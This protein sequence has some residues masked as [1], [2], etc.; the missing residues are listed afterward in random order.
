MT[1]EDAA[2]RR[3]GTLIANKYRLRRVIGRGGMGAVYDSVH[4]FTGK[5]CAVKVLDPAASHVAGYA[6]RFLREARAAAQIG[7]PG[8][9]DVLDAGQDQDDGSLYLV[10]ELLEGEDLGAAMRRGDLTTSEIVEIGAQ[11]LDA[12]AAAHGRGIVHR[13]IKPENVFLTRDEHGNLRVKLLDFGVAKEMSRGKQLHDTTQSGLLIGTP[14]YMAPEQVSGGDLDGRA[15]VWATGA[16]LFHALSEGPP[17]DAPSYNKLLLK[18]VS[19]PAPSLAT[20]R[21]DLPKWLVDVV[22]RALKSSAAERWT[23]SQMATWL[24][25]KGEVPLSLD[26]DPHEDATQR[27]DSLFPTDTEAA[28]PQVDLGALTPPARSRDADMTAPQRPSKLGVESQPTVAAPTVSAARK[29]SASSA[30][31][32][33]EPQATPQTWERPSQPGGS[34]A[35]VVIGIVVGGL[36]TLLAAFTVTWW[37][38]TRSP[39]A[40]GPVSSPIPL[41]PDTGVVERD[42]AEPAVDAD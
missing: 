13:D 26:W 29:T 18:I 27:T 15:D 42:A 30:P 40:P 5:V 22:D 6:A 14:Y 2:A 16:M 25:A 10:L 41:A 38:L 32:S 20:Y 1:S 12:L 9:C 35:G 34:R 36:L 37:L 31:S 24:R 21:S 8:I 11:V 33:G 28:A 23:A 17:F 7:H 4:S 39:D 19:E 3:V